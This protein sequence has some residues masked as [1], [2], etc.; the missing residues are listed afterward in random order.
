MSE[1]RFENK[2]LLSSGAASGMGFLTCERFVREGGSVLMADIN[3]AALEEAV[4]RIN[5]IRPGAAVG[6]V[7]DV[8]DYAQ[9]TAARDKAVAAFGRIDVVT[10]FAGGS[11]MRVHR[12]GKIEFPDVP[13]EVY[14]WGIDVN[15]KGQFYMDHAVMRQMREQK[16]GVIINI[17]SITGAEGSATSVAY[18]ASKSGAM[19]GLTRSLAQY[20]ARYG[21]RCVCVSPGPVLT[22]AAMAKMSTLLERAADPDEIVETVLFVA[23]EKG[24]FFDG[25]D[26]LLD[27]G[28][29]AM[30]RGQG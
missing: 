5:A 24:S 22:R 11:E 6:A 27:G 10:N 17:G 15:L 25:T 1:K 16:S 12:M 30:K 8:R 13:I 4:G 28:R 19:I 29:F 14:D 3:P 23:S 9:V 18:S 7:C 26:L 2:V 20:G 21:I